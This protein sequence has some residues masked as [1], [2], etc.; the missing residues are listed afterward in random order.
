[1]K[2]FLLSLALVLGIVSYASAGTISFT[3]DQVTLTESGEYDSSGNPII[4]GFKYDNNLTTA[5]GPQI[6]MDNFTPPRPSD[7]MPL[8]KGSPSSS[9]WHSR[10]PHDWSLL[11]WNL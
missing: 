8:L 11:F 5:I 1:M 7:A 2:K 4:K 3:M 10:L 9:A 6:K